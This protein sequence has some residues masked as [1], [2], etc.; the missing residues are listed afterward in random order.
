MMKISRN[1][2]GNRDSRL[3]I[4]A[5]ERILVETNRGRNAVTGEPTSNPT[6]APW[7]GRAL[8]GWRDSIRL[9]PDFPNDNLFTATARARSAA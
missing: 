8:S 4:T 3:T 9:Q 1:A 7:I 5:T 2:D 6:H